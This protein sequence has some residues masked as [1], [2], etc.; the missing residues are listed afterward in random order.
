M[1]ASTI[2]FILDFLIILLLGTTIFY[3]AR[4][5]I[6]LKTFRQGRRE[7]DKLIQDLS[8]SIVRAE[9]AIEGLKQTAKKEGEQL[10]GIVKKAQ[11]SIDELEIITQAGNNM[12]NRLETVASKNGDIARGMEQNSSVTSLDELDQRMTGSADQVFDIQDPEFVPDDVDDW[13]GLEDL[14]SDAEKELLKALK[15]QGRG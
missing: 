6:H 1:A 4:L 5:S 8:S 14:Q 12:A 7:M 13:D 11:L 9:G 2:G 3:A 15:K 10:Y